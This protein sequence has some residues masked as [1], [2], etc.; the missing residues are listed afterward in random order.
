MDYTTYDGLH[1]TVT[2]RLNTGQEWHC[3]A[4]GEALFLRWLF[5]Y[6]LEWGA[7]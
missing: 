2:R 7:A 4:S 6:W 3:P 5:L 1:P